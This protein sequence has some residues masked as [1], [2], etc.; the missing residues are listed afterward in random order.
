MFNLKYNLLFILALK[1]RNF[2][3]NF[4]TGKINISRGG[5]LV[6]RGIRRKNLYHL[7]NIITQ[8]ALILTEENYEAP[9]TL[10]SPYEG[11]EPLPTGEALNKVIAPTLNNY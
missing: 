7:I 11:E 1:K 9:G 5:I 2:K 10:Q 4:N 3:I 8:L 6:T